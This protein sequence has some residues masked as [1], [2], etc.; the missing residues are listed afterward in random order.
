MHAFHQRHVLMPHLPQ[1]LK[2]TVD[3]P[4]PPALSLHTEGANVLG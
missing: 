3:E 2:G 1:V 4:P